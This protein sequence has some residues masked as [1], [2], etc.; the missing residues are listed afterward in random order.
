MIKHIIFDWDGTLVNTVR[1]LKKSFEETF[2][3][4]HIKNINYQ[5]IRE[6]CAAHPDKN[7]FELV[8]A[9]DIRTTAKL[10]TWNWGR[11][12]ALQLIIPGFLVLAVLLSLT[13]RVMTDSELAKYFAKKQ[14]IRYA[15]EPE[16]VVDL[17]EM[18][19]AEFFPEYVDVNIKHGTIAIIARNDG[20]WRFGWKHPEQN[21]S[22]KR[23]R[24]IVLESLSGTK[25]LNILATIMAKSR[26]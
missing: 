26:S 20:R 13:S 2:A 9:P 16:Y 21:P 10:P 5:H 11:L 24:A 6:V 12:K 22:T 1:F 14:I 25:I 7:I 15:D 4:F 3:H 17:E 23:I 18:L 19:C 8:F